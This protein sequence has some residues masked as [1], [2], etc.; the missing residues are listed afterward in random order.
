M[1]QVRGFSQVSPHGG[2]SNV[3]GCWDLFLPQGHDLRRLLGQSPHDL[4]WHSF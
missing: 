3:H 2:T 1:A 4:E